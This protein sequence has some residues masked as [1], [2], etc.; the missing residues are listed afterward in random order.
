M[1]RFATI[2]YEVMWVK[3][4]FIRYTESFRQIRSKMEY[5][6][7]S[8]FKCGHAFEDDEMMA[9]ASLRKISNK[10]FCQKCATELIEVP[11]PQG[12]AVFCS[13]NL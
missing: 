4:D 6:M 12:D 9:L 7:S 11:H 13:Q 5:R 8:C 3:L 2:V 10:V 1:R